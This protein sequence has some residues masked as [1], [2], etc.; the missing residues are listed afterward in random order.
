MN[1]EEGEI[2][3]AIL[4]MEGGRIGRFAKMKIELQKIVFLKIAKKAGFGSR[5]CAWDFITTNPPLGQ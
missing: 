3:A 2:H 1:A 4:I 5:Q